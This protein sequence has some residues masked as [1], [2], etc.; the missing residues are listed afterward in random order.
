MRRGKGRLLEDKGLLDLL[1][2]LRGRLWRIIL[3]VLVGMSVAWYYYDPL[4]DLILG[5]VGKMLRPGKDVLAFQRPLEPLLT[6]IWICV[7][8]GLAST[9]PLIALEVWAFLSP[10]LGRRERKWGYVI[11]PSAFLLFWGGILATYKVLP[12]IFYILRK[13]MP[14]SSVVFLFLSPHACASFIA[15]IY[16]AAG[17]VFQMPLVFGVLA[18]LGLV[19][20]KFL[21]SKWRHAVVAILVIMAI[22]TPTWDAF[23]MLVASVPLVFLYFASILVVRLVQRKEEAE[24]EFAVT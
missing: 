23:T 24:E 15:K 3:Y 5:P 10:A 7:A 22:L 2:E 16:L 20:S 11:V 21:L 1:E 9:M 6:K 13:F 12:V 18:R 4:F 17:A 19:D 14:S 8:A